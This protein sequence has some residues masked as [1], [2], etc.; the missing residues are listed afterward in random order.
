MFSLSMFGPFRR[1]VFRGSVPFEVQFFDVQSFD[2]WS[3]STFSLSMFGPFRGSVF[4]SSVFWG[5]VFRGSV[6]RHSVFRGSV[7]RGSVI[8]GSVTVSSPLRFDGPRD[9]QAGCWFAWADS[10]ATFSQFKVKGNLRRSNESWK[11]TLG[12]QVT[13][14]GGVIA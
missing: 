9:G 12:S 11:T 2:V 1:S 3:H 4:W 5:S 13:K 10:R 7:F 6:F 8:W 14:T